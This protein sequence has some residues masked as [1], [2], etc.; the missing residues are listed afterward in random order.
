MSKLY[1]EEEIAAN[2]EIIEKLN[3]NDKEEDKN[4]NIDMETTEE[5]NKE[6]DIANEEE[7]KRWHFGK[8]VDLSANCNFEMHVNSENKMIYVCPGKAQYFLASSSKCCGP[9]S[10]KYLGHNYDER[11]KKIY[12]CLGT[13]FVF[14]SGI[15][16]IPKKQ[17]HPGAIDVLPFLAYDGC[18]YYKFEVIFTYSPCE[19][20]KCCSK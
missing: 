20:C 17:L 7:K 15:V 9:I 8:H 1:Y 3:V 11:C 2:D 19:C 4:L 14:D 16:I 13:Y 18:N 6:I 12:G 10:V 5:I